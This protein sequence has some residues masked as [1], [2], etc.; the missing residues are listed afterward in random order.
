MK[1]LFL[2]LLCAAACYSQSFRYNATTG[3]A[4]LVAAGTTFT[5]QQPAANAKLVTLE[6]AVVYC[7]IACN[8]TQAQ[9]GSAATATAGTA[10]SIMP[11]GPAAVAT[12]WTGSNVGAGTATAG[13]LHLAA[14]QF[15][16]LDLSKVVMGN[17]GSGTNYSITV[18]SITGTANITLY[19]NER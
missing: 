14:G 5:I 4:S 3:D 15:W 17:S 16:T 6:T 13:I 2:L 12:V 19:W 11:L 8:V 7:S 1:K 18:S 9:N 10:N